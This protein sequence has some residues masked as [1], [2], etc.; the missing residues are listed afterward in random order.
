MKSPTKAA[1]EHELAMARSAEAKEDMTVAMHHL[2]RAHILGQRWYL[3]HIK[4]HVKMLRLALKGSNVTEARGQLIRLL[5]AAPF[6]I[7]GWVPIG[8]T[9]GSNVSPIQPMPV[10]PDLRIYLVG[11]SLRTGIIIRGALVILFAS[12][13]LINSH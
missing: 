9:G 3:A 10:P 5:G 11:R 12:V 1:F 7:A 8:N 6:H 4:T 2:E 13:Y